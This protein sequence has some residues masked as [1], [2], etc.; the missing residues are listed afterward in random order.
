MMMN[1]IRVLF[2]A[3]AAQIVVNKGAGARKIDESERPR[4][5]IEEDKPLQTG[6]PIREF[7]DI[8]PADIE[9][10]NGDMD[11]DGMFEHVSCDKASGACYHLDN[12][13]VEFDRTMRINDYRRI[14]NNISNSNKEVGNNHINVNV[15]QTIEDHA[16]KIDQ[17]KHDVEDHVSDKLTLHALVIVACVFTPIMTGICIKIGHYYYKEHCRTGAAQK[18]ARREIFEEIEGLFK[19]NPDHVKN[20]FKFLLAQYS[21]TFCNQFLKKEEA[22]VAKRIHQQATDE[23]MRELV[24]TKATNLG[25]YHH[26]RDYNSTVAGSSAPLPEY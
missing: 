9:T 22:T 15:L 13:N 1:M 19:E 20:L 23:E 3:T 6:A 2:V 7:A 16:A 17:I 5:P 24:E 14:Q 4:I 26:G 11:E 8:P 18:R 12:G 21:P 25:Y 10:F